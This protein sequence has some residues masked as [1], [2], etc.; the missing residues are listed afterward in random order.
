MA[1]TREEGT[2]LRFYLLPLQLLGPAGGDQRAEVDFPDVA[3]AS[4]LAVASC[5]HVE[6]VVQEDRGVKPPG[7]GTRFVPGSGDLG[8][9][10]GLEV[11]DPEV[12]EIGDAFASEDDEVGVK[13]L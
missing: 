4:V 11:E 2:P 6:V 7:A 1:P 12:V 8:P 5:D 3:E 9:F 10:A 13:Y